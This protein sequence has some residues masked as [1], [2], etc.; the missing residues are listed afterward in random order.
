MDTNKRPTNL[1]RAAMLGVAVGAL[2]AAAPVVAQETDDSITVTGSRIQKQDFVAN[3]PVTT[4]DS[5]TL[6]LTGTVNVEDLLN[7]LPQTIPGFDSTSNNPGGGFATVNLRG[8]GS[9]RTLVL[10]DGT[11]MVPTTLAGVVDLNNIPAALI[12]SVEV[13]TGGASAVYGSDAIGGVVNFIMKKDFEGMEFVSGYQVTEDGDGDIF[14]MNLTAGSNFADGRGNVSM[15]MGYTSRQAVLQGDRAFSFEALG[16]NDSNGDGIADEFSPFGSSGVP[17]TR[18]FANFDWTAA[19]VFNPGACPEGLTDTGAICRGGLTFAPDGSPIPWINGGQNTTRFNYAPFNYLQLPQE[20]Y[21]ASTMFNYQVNDWMEVYGRVLFAQNKVPQQLAPTPAFTT[22]TTQL[23][24]PFLNADARALLSQIAVGGQAS[25]F[26]GRRMLEV[27]PRQSNDDRTSFQFKTGIRGDL[28]NGMHYD[29]YFQSGRVQN[30]KDLV[31]DVD[32]GR[33]K[34]AAN[35]TVDA[36]GN[37]VCV[38][39]SNG[40]VAMN[41]F[42]EGNIS[43]AAADFVR[44]RLNSKTEYNQIVSGGYLSGDLGSIELPG[45]PINWVIG[46]E[47]REEEAFF[48]PSQ[49]LATGNVLGFGSAPAISGGYDVYDVYG[50]VYA[51]ILEGVPGAELLAFEG[52]IRLSEYS[53]VGST[54]AWKAGG[55][56]VPVDGFEVR[57]LYNVAVR[58]PN[59]GELFSPQANGFPGAQ[60]PCSAG[61]N[62]V[63]AGIAA[64]CTTLGVPN[65]GDGV[66]NGFYEQA[67]T[68]IEGLFGGNPNLGAETADTFTIGAVVSPAMVPGLTFS[69]D[70]WSIDISDVITALTVNTILNNCFST[71]TNPGLSAAN[72]FC[73]QIPRRASG[74]PFRV[75]SLNQNSAALELAGVDVQVNYGFDLEDIM[76]VPGH[77]DLSY[78]G[79]FKN[80]NDFTP[81]PS[82]TPIV[83]DGLFGGLCGEPDPSYSHN[84]S[85]RWSMDNYGVQLRWTMIGSVDDDGASGA[86]VVNKIDT[87]HYFDLNASWDVNEHFRIVGGVDNIFGIDPKVLGNNQEQANTY[88]ATYDVFGRVFKISGRARF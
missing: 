63:A 27:G 55:R 64:L 76:P 29:W 61:N 37:A 20:R 25:F 75:L 71:V 22:V 9:N 45:G 24:N 65:V 48:S 10:V 19:G 77:L 32:A 7:D 43:A 85:A 39:T 23:D 18:V 6:V 11:R 41:I 56:W 54:T 80:K 72:T 2:A 1:R 36:A 60:D 53:T 47:Y 13:L 68:Q 12:E 83:C 5:E 59:I 33:F 78:I 38:D 21:N 4:V 50:E 46:G 87:T 84:V 42:G 30:N 57:G 86:V 88:P 40:C 16:D 52:A 62:P 69:V 70:Y 3:S 14:N 8:A 15:S 17:G 34:Q 66:G 79:S 58:A 73:G 26:I 82:Q 28:P 51:P 31:G 74:D 81:D 67:N 35:V 49:A 44:L